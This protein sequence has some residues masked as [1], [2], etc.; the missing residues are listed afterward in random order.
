M[1]S[2]RFTAVTF[3]YGNSDEWRGY[4]EE[5]KEVEKSCKT[6]LEFWN[7]LKKKCYE[8]KTFKD[9]QKDFDYST[10][11]LGG[12]TLDGK[13]KERSL[14][15]VYADLFGFKPENI[16]DL[17]ERLRRGISPTT[18]VVV[19]ETDFIR[20]VRSVSDKISSILRQAEVK[21]L[22]DGA[23]VDVEV[24]YYGIL[25]DY[26][27][28]IGIIEDF[29]NNVAKI[30]P[31]YHQKSLFVW[32]LD[33]LTYRYMTTAY[34]ELRDESVFE[35]VKDILG[36]EVIF[37]PDV[38]DE[39]IRRDYSVYSYYDGSIG[40]E[41]VELF[42]MIWKLFDGEYIGKHISDLKIRWSLDC[43]KIRKVL[44]LIFPELPNPKK[45]FLELATNALRSIGWKFPD[46]IR[47]VGTQTRYLDL[48]V[49]I[50]E[51]KYIVNKILI[52]NIKITYKNLSRDKVSTRS[53]SDTKE[54]K[55]PLIKFLDE[56]SPMVFLLHEIEYKFI[57]G[58]YSNNQY[59]IEIK[60]IEYD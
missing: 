25:S 27:K 2:Q 1:D 51:A 57:I 54:L 53:Y 31:N 40:R 9:L 58:K 32:T 52:S 50:D 47:I 8:F 3:D 20:F 55:L 60:I 43:E 23:D 24:D 44:L 33:K 6:I 21:G 22:I 56:L 19:E 42:K 29:V 37:S 4:F 49:R 28:L 36:L 16:H 12:V 17:I 48:K 10:V 35:L 34:P 11:L 59:Y 46:Y 30:L 15:K 26:K 41:L 45:E 14:A 38:E 13:Y 39:S 5:L 7:E 18:K